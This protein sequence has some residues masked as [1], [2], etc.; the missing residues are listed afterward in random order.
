LARAL[1]PREVQDEVEAEVAPPPEWQ[2]APREEPA[3]AEPAAQAAEE[4]DLES[5]Q[6]WLQSLKR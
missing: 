2:E 4:E 6:A 5:F 1:A 3:P